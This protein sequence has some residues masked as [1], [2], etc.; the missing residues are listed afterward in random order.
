MAELKAR[1]FAWAPGKHGVLRD[2]VRPL[3]LVA[4]VVP[5]VLVPPVAR[6]VIARAASRGRE[7]V[8]WFMHVVTAAARQLCDA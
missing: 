6:H 1:Q 5:A 8:D 3:D 2:L 7:R 4:Q